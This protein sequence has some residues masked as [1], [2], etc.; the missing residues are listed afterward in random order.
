MRRLVS[1]VVVALVAATT[2]VT[3][4]VTAGTASA[5]TRPVAGA[6]YVWANSPTT[7]SY[8]PHLTYQMNSISTTTRNTITRRG[9]GYYAVTFTGLGV[10]GGVAH[11]TA[12]GDNTHQCKPDTWV[13][14][15]IDQTVVIRCYTLAGAPVDTRFTASFTN[16][17]VWPGFEYGQ[18]YPGGYVH[19]T[20]S[21]SATSTPPYHQ[22]F[23][24][25]GMTNTVSRTGVG[26]YKVFM[27]EIGRTTRAGHARVTS[28]GWGATRCKVF[29]FGWGTPASTIQVNI[30]CFNAA[31]TP[32]DS[33]FSM[34]F[35]DRT[36]TFGLNGCCNPDGHQSAYA[37]ANNATAA[38]YTPSLSYQHEVP[39]GVA[40]ATRSGTGNYAMHFANADLATGHVHVAATNSWNAEFCKVVSWNSS[41]GI[42]VRCYSA[43]G[44]PVDTSYQIDHTGPY[45]L[46]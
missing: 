14:S 19:L 30:R 33:G 11:A 28:I 24:S 8:T 1:P 42:N 16:K 6:G 27:P 40:T 41:I 2:V 44:A 13:A 29:N 17:R 21:S 15:G 46:G 22:Q 10:S 37:L 5:D 12:Y 32:T 3:A 35:T 45:L 38:S 39:S 31:G 20:N 34:T 26:T 23:N 25:A 18:T 4:V 7:A 9:T 36:N 43:T